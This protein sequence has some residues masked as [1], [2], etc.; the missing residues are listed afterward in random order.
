LHGLLEDI[1]I[2]ETLKPHSNKFLAIFA[3]KTME[4]IIIYPDDKISLDIFLGLAKKLK[5]KVK[6]LKAEQLEDLA[7]IKAIDEGRKTSFTTK[8]SIVKKLKKQP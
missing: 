3:K 6:H 5:I 2:H 8:T 4:A 1:I 7:L